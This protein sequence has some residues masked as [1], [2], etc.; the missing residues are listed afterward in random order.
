MVQATADP[1]T[2]PVGRDDGP[3]PAPP[4][5]A[6]PPSAPAALTALLLSDGESPA[7]LHL[8]GQLTHALQR[9][10]LLAIL[11]P[12]PAGRTERERFR[13]WLRTLGVGA[14]VQV[15]GTSRCD[16][17]SRQVQASLSGGIPLYGVR[18]PA[19]E[20]A[21]L[22]FCVDDELAADQV[23][24]YLRGLGHTAIGCLLDGPGQSAATG[25]ESTYR[26]RGIQR[27]SLTSTTPEG[28]RAATDAFLDAGCTAVVCGSALLA[29]GAL[30]TIRDRGLSAPGDLS[31][32][33]LED[34]PPGRFAEP[35]LTAL[36][37]PV[38][39][40]AESVADVLREALV[41][42]PTPV[43]RLRFLGASELRYAPDLVVRGSTGPAPVAGPAC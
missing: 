27:V 15:G 9:R 21:G 39:Q 30:A 42:A 17:P 14:L 38:R 22:H 8:A 43:P 32:I 37:P 18:F 4:Y 11:H 40:M 36:Q 34:A 3:R 23:L 41:D 19:E 25:R 13:G 29:L 20:S 7:L 28:V 26:A 1:A 12:E 35:T 16:R 33:S 24:G 10:G 6:Q 31:L 2:R 5:R